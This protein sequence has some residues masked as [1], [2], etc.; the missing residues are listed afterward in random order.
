MR[1]QSC[2]SVGTS[3]PNLI[4]WIENIARSINDI[5][6][7]LSSIVVINITKQMKYQPGQHFTPSLWY[8]KD[9]FEKVKKTKQNKTKQQKKKKKKKKKN[10]L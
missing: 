6:M 10:A 1:V 9:C 7:K 2:W 4:H 3:T 5:L 8:N